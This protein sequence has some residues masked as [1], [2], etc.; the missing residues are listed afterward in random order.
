[1]DRRGTGSFRATASMDHFGIF[2]SC[3]K[4]FAMLEPAAAGPAVRAAVFGRA[5]EHYSSILANGLVPGPA[6]R[7]FFGRMA[8]D[9]RRDR[10]PGYRRPA[11]LR[12]LKA[13][14]LECD[15]CPPHPMPAP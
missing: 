11:G 5:V 14:L 15:A 3:A 9:F 12:R 7:A 8:A 10:P 2:A 6:R 4:V 13:A 1:M